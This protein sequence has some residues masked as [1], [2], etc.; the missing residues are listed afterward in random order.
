MGSLAEQV[1]TLNSTLE[2][3]EFRFAQGGVP[4][5]GLEALKSS[6]DDFRLRVWGVLVAARADDYRAFQE[7]F[8]IRRAKEICREVGSDL[9]AGKMS[10]AHSELPDLAEAA[11]LL[12]RS[13]NLALHQSSLDGSG[14]PV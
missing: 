3:I 8:R 9:R 7:R 4:L 12:T 14:G 5:E 6:V 11:S 1:L 2:A 13:I 10:G